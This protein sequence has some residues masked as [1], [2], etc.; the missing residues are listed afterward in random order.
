MTSAESGHREMGEN[1]RDHERRHRPQ[2]FDDREDALQAVRLERETCDEQRGC[3]GGA[4]GKP[5]QCRT[6][7]GKGLVGGKSDPEDQD[8]GGEQRHPDE[9]E[10]MHRTSE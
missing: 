7:Q 9:R 1:R 5:G 4:E 3:D 8:S 2:E 6:E 10:V